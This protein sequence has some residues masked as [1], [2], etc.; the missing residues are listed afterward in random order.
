MTDRPW[1]TEATELD[2]EADGLACK[3]R[4]G[5][6]DAWCGYVGVGESHPLYGLPTNH[7]LALPPSWFAGRTF[8]QGIG[9]F[10]M[11]I[12]ML[13]GAKSME[14]ACPISMA[15]HVHGGLNWAE[16]RVPGCE[17]DGRWWFGFD[18]GHAGDY[19]PGKPKGVERMMDEMVDSMPEHVRDTM[20]GIIAK[21][22][23]RTSDYRDQQYVVSECQSLAAQLNAVVGV[24]KMETTHGSADHRRD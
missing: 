19:V 7:P 15:F 11:F 9:P 13:G 5:G 17:P 16:N 18:C 20:R 12:H 10:D 22:A 4:R 8:D 2:F 14:D 6:Y 24:L 23:T 21:S 3:M 1:E